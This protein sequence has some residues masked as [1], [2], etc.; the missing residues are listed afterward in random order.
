[1]GKNIDIVDLKKQLDV[2]KVDA[3][4]IR[5]SSKIKDLKE[6]AESDIRRS[7]REIHYG[8]REWTIETVIQ[9]YSDGLEDDT[10]E[11]FIPDYQ[12]D[13]KWDLKIASRFVESIMLSFP[14]PY[15]YIADV[16]SPDDPELD[17]RAEIIDGS[18]RV[19]ALYYFV[20]NQFPL[21]EL[22]ELHSLEGFYF[23]DLLASR[24]RRFL[25][26]SLRLVE[27]VGEVDE[28][29][30]RDLFERINSGVK[31]LEAM[32]VRHGSE[33]ANSR[34]YR[35][36]ILPCSKNSLFA[37]L[38]PLSEKKRSNQD[39]IELALRYFAYVYDIDSYQ[40]SVKPF[41]DNY[42]KKAS[43]D[44]VDDQRIQSFNADFQNTLEFINIYFGDLGFKK[45]IRSKTTPRAR[46][47]AIAVGVA[48]ALKEEPELRPAIDVST[49]LTSDEFQLVVGADSANNETQLRNRI[50]FVKN[51]LLTGE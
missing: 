29:S 31:R 17:G 20:N 42:L 46:Y 35:E 24:K 36:V 30:R 19:R 28:S 2:A 45:S 25:R 13:Y 40:G 44:I 8:I 27:L 49:W 39:H 48:L 11:L 37:K 16:N 41:L 5:I 15:L 14:I 38:A 10:N 51:K 22:K 47:E 1:M 32:E 33:E 9:K 18:Q 50:N 21:T 7:N 34:F 26:E 43:K 6:K 12:R 3:E 23:D 4:R